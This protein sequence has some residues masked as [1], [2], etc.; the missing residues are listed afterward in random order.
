MLSGICLIFNSI[1]CNVYRESQINWL[2]DCIYTTIISFVISVSVSV[3]IALIRFIS[4]KCKYRY[5][6]N[7]SLYINSMFK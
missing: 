3:I 1:F 5:L 6:Y 4:L 7:I 2:T